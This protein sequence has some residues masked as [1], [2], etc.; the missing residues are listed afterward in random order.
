MA[1]ILIVCQ[2]DNGQQGIT[3][4]N[5]FN[6]FTEH[7]SRCLTINESYLKYETDLLYHKY[8]N[9]ELRQLLSD[10]DFFI[11][12]ESIPWEIMSR[13]GLA[14]RINKHNTIIRVG[15]TFCRRRTNDYLMLWLREGFM[16]TGSMHDWSLYGKIGRI[17]PTRNILPIEKMPEPSPPNDI[18][19]VAFSPTKQ[20][21]GVAEFNRVMTQLIKEY[22]E[23]V[24]AVEIIGKPWEECVK[25]K[26]HATHTFDQMLVST[27]ANNCIESMY[28]GHTVLSKIDQWTRAL[29]PDLPVIGVNSEQDL[30]HKLK[31]VIEEP[32]RSREIGKLGREFVLRYH[33]P[34][35]V[36]RTWE[37]LIEHVKTAQL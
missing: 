14:D 28:L 4:N 12:S 35:S 11:F 36:I 31:Q 2:W 23:S 16:L 30:Y 6:K 21:K 32:E 18:I 25:I 29:Y 15:G 26:A 7:E 33:T 20:K 24:E 37:S 10:R 1:R 19:R 27:Y 3:L 5:A 9:L 34:E 13:I 8:S 22:P 17:A